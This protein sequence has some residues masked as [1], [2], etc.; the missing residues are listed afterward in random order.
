MAKRFHINPETGDAGRCR[1]RR[2]CPFGDMSTD[3]FDTADAAR[4]AYEKRMERAEAKRVESEEAERRRQEY[5]AR[6]DV[7]AR[8]AKANQLIRDAAVIYSDDKFA[9]WSLEAPNSFKHRLS[10]I[11]KSW[12]EGKLSEDEFY[13]H[14]EMAAGAEYSSVI[15]NM[16]AVATNLVKARN[17]AR[18]EQELADTLAQ[19]GAPERKR[20][21]RF[22]TESER[23]MGPATYETEEFYQA[24]LALLRGDLEF[25]TPLAESYY[26]R[27]NMELNGDPKS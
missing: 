4:E 19:A 10:N 6:P 7:V 15:F 26:V 11:H 27:Y 3:H 1:A 8:D 18:L 23:S 17:Q 22:F 13:S 20:E 2:S 25:V 14:L 9:S 21:P 16:E 5:L 24:K 12:K